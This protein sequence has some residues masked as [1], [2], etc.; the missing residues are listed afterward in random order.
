HRFA[1]ER[2][3]GRPAA[4]AETPFGLL[5]YGR[6]EVGATDGSSG[7]VCLDVVGPRPRDLDAD[8]AG[9]T[10]LVRACTGAAE[11]IF[12]V[13]RRARRVA[14]ALYVLAGQHD[15]AVL[16]RIAVSAGAGLREIGHEFLRRGAF[17]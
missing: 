8:V 13:A 4:V 7:A 5:V 3:D 15:V 10:L 17:V 16:R 9:R 6:H 12:E 14:D 1:G 11:P 2:V